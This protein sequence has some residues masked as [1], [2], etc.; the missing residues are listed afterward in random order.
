MNGI[1]SQVAKTTKTL[2]QQAAKQVA[3]EPLEVI[4]AGTKQ[5]AGMEKTPAQVTQTP[6]SQT[7]PAPQAPNIEALKQQDVARSRQLHEKL[8]R[9]IKEI[10]EKEQQKK[11]LQ[12][13][14]QPQPVE[15]P[16]KPLQEPAAKRSRRLF[17]FGPKT[18]AERKRTRV[19]R[20]Q[21]PTG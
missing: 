2:A 3:Q 8:E 15:P 7:Q 19:E 4:K 1:K 16:I 11:I 12:A 6:V 9:E 18:A 17:S 5:V 21:P 20:V 10:R 14:A 13:Q